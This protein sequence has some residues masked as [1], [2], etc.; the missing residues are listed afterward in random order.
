LVGVFDFEFDGEVG[1]GFEG[2][3]EFGAGFVVGEAEMVAGDEEGAIAGVAVEGDEGGRG[4]EDGFEEASGLGEVFAG[5]NPDAGEVGEVGGFFDV[6]A[7]DGRRDRGAEGMGAVALEALLLA[8]LGLEGFLLFEFAGHVLLHDLVDVF[9]G[10]GGVARGRDIRGRGELRAAA[11]SWGM[12]GSDVMIRGG[13]QL[14]ASARSFRGV[15]NGRV[16]GGGV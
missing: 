15:G 11:G 8:E 9:L 16:V 5:G 7:L 6:D 14:R 12:R 3:F 2:F 10:L 13:S 1:D 4:A